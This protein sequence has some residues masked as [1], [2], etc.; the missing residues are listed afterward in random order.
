M[1]KLAV[2]LEY[3]ILSSELESLL[4]EAELIRTLQ[5]QFN[6]LLKDDKSSLYIVVTKEEFPKIVKTRKRELVRKNIS[7]QVIGPFPSSYKLNEVLKIVRPIFKWCDKKTRDNQACFYHHLD[8]CSG[9]CVRQIT[10]EEYQANI[11]QLVLFLRGKKKLVSNNLRMMMKQAA[12]EEKFELANRY[13]QMIQLIEEV[14]NPEFRLKPDLALPV[15]QLKQK[16]IGL[17]NL[18]Q[19]MGT[20]LNNLPPNYPLN[21]IEGYDVSNIQGTNAAVSMV[22]FIN[23]QPEKK[24]YR[25]FNIRTLKTP[26]DFAMLKEALIRRQNHPEWGKPDLIIIDGGKGQLK[27]AL[28]AWKWPNPVISIEKHPDRLIFPRIT[29]IEGRKTSDYSVI[30]LE[31]EHPAL[32]LVA[33]VRDESHRFAKKQHIRLRTKNLLS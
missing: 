7:G 21:R 8:L 1:V 2:K 5:P 24:L 9:A 19:M 30:K 25:V 12:K 17:I 31:K 32:K 13:K 26:N 27:S 23:G 3:Q 14:T 11:K 15:F 29:S 22:V 6:V 28:A 33:N 10:P 20:Y 16:E 18:S 4:V